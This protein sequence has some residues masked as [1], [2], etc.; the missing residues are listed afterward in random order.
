[1]R[2]LK[3]SAIKE[4]TVI[5]HLPSEVTF[6]ILEILGLKNPDTLITVA[7]N[8]QS[9]HMGTKGII[10]IGSRFLTPTE[11]DKIAILAPSAVINIIKD[12]KVVEKRPVSIPD[13]IEAVARCSNPNCITNHDEATSKFFTISRDPLKLRCHYCERVMREEDVTIL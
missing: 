7:T 4:G 13:T 3:V 6:K 8:L 12:Y 10:K 5:D 11:A 2:I 9:K 1:M